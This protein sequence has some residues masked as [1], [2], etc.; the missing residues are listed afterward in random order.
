MRGRGG[1]NKN[2]QNCPHL[3]N[4]WLLPGK[5]EVNIHLDFQ[6]LYIFLQ[7]FYVQRAISLVIIE[8]RSSF[9]SKNTL[10]FASPTMRHKVGDLIQG[11]LFS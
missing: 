8:I 7:F 10:H 4:E 6:F 5:L 9:W 1:G 2:R 11:N 3:I